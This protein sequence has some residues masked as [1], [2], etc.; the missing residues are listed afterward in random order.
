MMLKKLFIP[1]LATILYALV[2]APLAG[3]STEESITITLTGSYTDLSLYVT[4]SNLWVDLNN[5]GQQETG[6]ELVSGRKAHKAIP[7]RFKPLTIYGS[8]I[9]E[10]NLYDADQPEQVGAIDLT[11]AKSLRILNLKGNP[12]EGTLDLRP[13]TN[14]VEA[15]L[16]ETQLEAIDA[17]QCYNLTHLYASNSPKLKTLTLIDC[18]RLTWLE[19]EHCV[20]ENPSLRGDISLSAIHLDDNNLTELS[21]PLACRDLRV[22]SVSNNPNL[23]ELSIRAMTSLTEL[24]ASRCGLTSIDI[25]RG[26]SLERVD[27]SC[28]ALRE[29]TL[30][31]NPNRLKELRIYQN[32]FSLEAMKQLVAALP[33]DDKS[34]EEKRLYAINTLGT[35][36]REANVCSKSSVA[37]ANHLGWDVYDYYGGTEQLY[38]GSDDPIID[39][40]KE[41]FVLTTQQKQGEELTIDVKGERLFV[42]LNGN[43]ICDAGESLEV[44]QNSVRLSSRNIVTVYGSNITR[45]RVPF[46]KLTNVDLSQALHIEI[47]DLNNNQLEHIDLSNLKALRE[48]DLSSNKL[49]TAILPQSAPITSLNLAFNQFGSITLPT[50][51]TLERLWVNHNKLST[52]SPLGLKAL[53][54]LHIEVNQIGLI[55]MRDLVSELTESD[56]S[57]MQRRLYAVKTAD[58]N[59]GNHISKSMVATARSRGWV[60]YNALTPGYP[61]EED[62]RLGDHSECIVITIAS[63]E[64][65][66]LTFFPK[67]IDCWVDL[68]GNDSSD[69][70]EEIDARDGKKRVI[71]LASERTIK[72]YGKQI[73]E[74]CV[75]DQMHIS[76]VDATQAHSIEKLWIRDNMLAE[77][78]LPE[79]QTLRDLDLSNNKLSGSIDLSPYPLLEEIYLAN[80]AYQQARVSGL[81]NL[82]ILSLSENQLSSIDLTDCNNIEELYLASNQLRS[83]DCSALNRLETLSVFRNQIKLTEMQQLI[84]GLNDLTP[85]S[86]YRGKIFNVLYITND[87][88]PSPEEHNEFSDEL[89]KLA[90]RK[91][92]TV[93]GWKEGGGDA[94]ITDSERIAT[95]PSLCL[96]YHP[97][98]TGWIIECL[99][100]T[101]ESCAVA[102]YTPEGTLLYRGD[103]QSQL[104][105]CTPLDKVI[106]SVGSQSCLLIR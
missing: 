36:P 61:G 19:A 50:Y 24:Y 57:A 77:I 99:D 23:K 85:S 30:H 81:Q 43:N 92:W 95:A 86:P 6:E 87:G 37:L 14:I 47:L 64:Q 28:N 51:R 60:V 49:Q 35:T 94:I 72:L 63:P 68:N 101:P 102:V 82:R 69:P 7:N 93:K 79:G 41:G 34:T 8:T 98:E 40:T 88:K 9:E 56:A 73:T 75:N 15:K 71:N 12:I 5:N 16:Q 52:F 70:G 11:H 31:I 76:K 45:V 21:I 104:E 3:Q 22:V 78:S 33:A 53:Q 96:S 100:T 44:G 18:N 59:E 2:S 13:C 84:T 27:L 20:L 54:E 90:S 89:I 48:L 106:L 103:L 74:L 42:D 67:G 26:V 17:T 32:N 29:L 66:E 91:Q 105:I 55:A 65:A 38:A 39:P 58:P 25:S 4:G 62:Q 46:S 80:N 10:C 83:V 97:T 1:L